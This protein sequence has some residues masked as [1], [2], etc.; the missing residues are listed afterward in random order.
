MFNHVTDTRKSDSWRDVITP[1]VQTSNFVVLN[2]ITVHRVIISD[3]KRVAS[4][5]G[6]AFSD[7][8]SSRTVPWRQQLSFCIFPGYILEKPPE[9]TLSHFMDVTLQGRKKVR[10]A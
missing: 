6:F 5:Q 10:N 1:I 4:F 2:N 3:R 8:K 7:K 9:K